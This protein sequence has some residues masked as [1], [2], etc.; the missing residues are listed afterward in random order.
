MAR[1]FATTMMKGATLAPLTEPEADTEFSGVEYQPFQPTAPQQR[2]TASLV[3]LVVL[4]L[5]FIGHIVCR[6]P[7]LEA[8][9]VASLAAASE[10][11]VCD[12]SFP[13]Q[14]GQCSQCWLC[15]AC[16][17]PPAFTGIEAK[18]ANGTRMLATQ[19]APLE[20]GVAP[21][22]ALCAMFCDDPP[23]QAAVS[24]A[25]SHGLN[26]GDGKDGSRSL[27]STMQEACG[28]P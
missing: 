12:Y 16:S 13:T 25:H 6:L 1:L 3:V 17:W 18:C 4:G 11:V 27:C 26:G 2:R 8:E 28:A 23:S 21:C 20:R 15:P 9:S 7:L 5:A 10:P 24:W 14:L 22:C 19:H